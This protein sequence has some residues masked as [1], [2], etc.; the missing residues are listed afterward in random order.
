MN[1]KFAVIG[2]GQFGMSIAKT[3]ASRGAE[4]IAI[5]N[6]LDKIEQIKEDVSYAV[7]LDATDLKA[8]S[9]QDI[10]QVD[11]VVVAIGEDFEALLLATA[12][13]LDLKIKRVIA[14]AANIQQR[15]I[16]EKIGVKEILSPEETV[17]KTVAETLLQPNL[18]SYIELPDDYE[19]VEIKTPKR[20]VNQ[21]IKDIQLREEF[22]LNLIT[23]KRSF[24]EQ[25]NGEIVKVQHVIGVPR[26]D[27]TLHESDLLIIMG[28]GK[29]IS[30]FVEINQ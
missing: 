29:D 11:A 20:V 5:D 17:G 1:G 27:T 9:A 10:N 26:P 14:R 16:L 24:E 15:M 6:D 8:L 23:I 22:D 7:A 3:L 19:I 25:K 21:A 13:V 28:K 30:K 12:H 18:R 4:V 2:L